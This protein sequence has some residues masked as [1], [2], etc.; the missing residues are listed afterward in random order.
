MNMKTF[1]TI[2]GAVLLALSCATA[3][4]ARQHAK[5]VSPTQSEPVFNSSD[6]NPTRDRDSSCFDST[7]LPQLYACSPHGG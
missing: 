5:R 1:L 4:D 6:Y 3:S 2:A 7:G